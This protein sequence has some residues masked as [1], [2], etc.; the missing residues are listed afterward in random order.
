MTSPRLHTLL[1]VC[2][3]TALAPSSHSQPAVAYDVRTFGAT[4][5]GQTLDS[6]A[7]NRAILAAAEAGGGTVVIPA[8][9]YLSYS[10]RLKSHITLHLAAGATLIAAEPPPAGQ[11]GGYDAPEPNAWNQFQDFGHSHWHNSLI[12]G[13]GLEGIAI[14]GPGRIYGRG[15]SRGNGRRTAL[16]VGAL[17]P[18]EPGAELPDVLKADGPFEPAPRPDLVPGPFGYPNARDAL[19]AGVANKA[20]ALKNCR[21]VTLRDFSILHGGHF[22]ILATGVDNLTI[23]NLVIDTNRDGMDIDACSNVRIAN[24]SVN[25]PWDDGI[26]LKSSHGLGFARVCENVTITNCFVSGYD[27]GTLLDGTRTRNTRR[28]GG[29]M[30]RIKLGT[31]AGG[32]FRNITISNCVFDYSRGIALEQVDGGVMED[33][34]ISNITLRDVQNSPLFIRLGGRLRR[35]DTTV[36]GTTRRIL[37]DNLVASNVSPDHGILIAGL[38]GHPIEDLVLSNLQIHYAGGGT[39]EQAAREVPELASAYPDPDVF[40]VMPSWGLFARHAANVQVRGVELRTVA[41]DARPAIHLEDIA[42][43]RFRDVVLVTP[44]GQP[45]WTVRGVTGLSVRDTSGR[46]DGETPP[47]IERVPR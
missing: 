4:G 21:N 38:P 2:L 9:D 20:I 10:I 1:L 16:P 8:G 12:W 31:E 41:A 6:D 17:L 15:L 47:A 23:D 13:E 30:G 19:P 43:A 42:G 11:A 39:S 34:A 5:D 40:G 27:E 25:S 28:Y 24:C 7:I 14:T 29:V 35:P 46:A 26:C 33:I 45:A 22:G 18:I 36:P 3:V 37:V 44:G 32:G